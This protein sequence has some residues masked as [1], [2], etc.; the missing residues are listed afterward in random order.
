MARIPEELMHEKQTK[1]RLLDA[2]HAEFVKMS[3]EN[4]Q[5]HSVMARICLRATLNYWNE[6]GK[7]P[8]FIEEQRA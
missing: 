4:G 2:E 5:L 6:H 1:V 3:H 8:D 7:L